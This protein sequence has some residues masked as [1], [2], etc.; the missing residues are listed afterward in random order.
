MTKIV[1]SGLRV[2]KG[3]YLMLILLNPIA[4]LA[5]AGKFQFVSGEVHVENKSGEERQARKGDQVSEGDVIVSG[6]PAL[7]QLKMDDGGTIVVRANTRVAIETFHFSGREDGT[8]RAVYKLEHGGIRAITGA[9]GKTNKTHYRIQTPTANIGVRGTDHEPFHIMKPASG[10]I[11]IGKPGTYD[12]VNVGETFIE[13]RKGLLVIK[14]N[15]VGYVEDENSVPALLPTIPDFYSKLNR[16]AEEHKTAASRS[17]VGTPADGGHLKAI[18]SGANVAPV[19]VAQEVITQE[20]LNLSRAGVALPGEAAETAPNGA[21]LAPSSDAATILLPDPILGPEPDSGVVAQPNPLP[22]P[23]TPPTIIP[24]LNPLPTPNP[25]S[26]QSGIGASLL[27]YSFL[28]RS[29]FNEVL[30][31]RDQQFSTAGAKLVESGADPTLHVQWGRWA[32]APVRS[33][34]SVTES[35]HF[36]NTDNLTARSLDSIV[37]PSNTATYNLVGGTQPTNELGQTGQL[38]KLQIVVDF[39]KQRISDY[40]V[41]VASDGRDWQASG[42]GSFR[43]FL[44]G[45][46][47]ISLKGTCSGCQ[48]AVHGNARGTFVGVSVE[49][50]IT[51][52]GLESGNKT[53]AGAAALKR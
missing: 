39:N 40:S 8:E 16:G 34:K 14:A 37:L 20:G 36:I 53:V 2:L 7:A 32:G 46:H 15:T 6:A 3:M 19:M 26:T 18:D 9:I 13:T 49:G 33:G 50:V 30:T 43:Q 24:G 42:E 1:S 48:R 5:A 25:G 10:E 31:G 12:K 27:S 21:I 51:T 44:R 29:G 41:A 38:K 11:P 47:G 52:F 17:D 23:S 4:C 22:D 35:L 28:T 45:G